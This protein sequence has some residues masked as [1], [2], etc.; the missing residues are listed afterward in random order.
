M[1]C[2]K[3]LGTLERFLRPDLMSHAI[4]VAFI[5]RMILKK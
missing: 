1:E 2:K 3:E 4:T 5:P